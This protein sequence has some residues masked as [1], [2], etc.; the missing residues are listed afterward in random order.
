MA[1]NEYNAALG[2]IKTIASGVTSG[3]SKVKSLISD[4][5][6]S[7]SAIRDKYLNGFL[8]DTTQFTPSVFPRLFDEPTYLTFKIEFNTDTLRN[9]FS[10][11]ELMGGGFSYD[12]LPEPLLSGEKVNAST[13]ENDKPITKGFETYS[14][15]SYLR[16][17]L[18]ET[19]RAD[20]L[21]QLIDEINDIQNNYPYYFT[22][23]SGLDA[24]AKVDPKKGIR[25]PDNTKITIKCMEGLDL[26]ITQLMQLYRK[27]AW[28]DVYQRWILPDM[29]RFFNL[30]IYISEMRLFHSSSVSL[31]RSTH[32][33]LYDFAGSYN[34]TIVDKNQLGSTGSILNTAGTIL[35][36]VSA[37]SERLLNENN[38]F[39][40]VVGAVGNTFET[41]TGIYSDIVTTFS[42]MC[43]NAINDVMPTICFDCHMCEFDI[44]NT[45]KH[46]SDLSSSN[47]KDSPTPSIVINVGQVEEVQMYPLNGDLGKDDSN[48]VY[49]IDLTKTHMKA[50]YI[51][52]DDLMREN[53]IMGGKN[54][55][56]QNGLLNDAFSVALPMKRINS[57]MV[58]MKED[59]YSKDG[60]SREA[61]AR[62]LLIGSANV[63]DVYG[64]DSNDARSRATHMT[65]DERTKMGINNPT[66]GVPRSLANDAKYNGN[67]NKINVAGRSKSTSTE[68]IPG[69]G[70]LLDNYD[71][72]TLSA[73]TRTL[74]R[75]RQSILN[76]DMVSSSNLNEDEKDRLR[77]ELYKN[78]LL[79][80]A[81]SPA[82]ASG[83]REMA[84]VILSSS[85]ERDLSSTAV[86]GNF[87]HTPINNTEPTSTATQPRNKSTKQ[88]N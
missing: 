69:M 88:F 60:E 33:K 38:G 86:D 24:L 6:K 54:Y 64:N 15:E 45:L 57:K 78:I 21:R 12:Y 50:A 66:E 72:M 22:S 29:M 44:E 61:A 82:T 3:I 13:I 26:K 14:T 27:I 37:V 7:A 16:Y 28:D 49:V 87:Q 11:S 79:D 65:N 18:G 34:S 17:T 47:R 83:L 19:K 51:S 35:S 53:T 58:N 4:P 77:N 8:G 2:G 20:M 75:V 36:R 62:S 81:T 25:L 42:R 5:G 59:S 73:A 67:P 74:E 68:P 76:N 41:A 30:K 84:G 48:D 56:D 43:N 63:V 23:I 52:D 70:K 10:I 46:I 80:I 9:I 1:I 39:N 55:A 40:Q 31:A 85:G 71:A 32:G